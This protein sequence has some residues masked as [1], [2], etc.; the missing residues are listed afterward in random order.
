MTIEIVP[1]I[2]NVLDAQL[3]ID[4]HPISIEL[5]AEVGATIEYDFYEGS[6]EFIPTMQE[7]IANTQNLIMHDNV[8]IK[9]IPQNYG[10]ITYNGFEIT[11]S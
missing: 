3:T 7:Q 1:I 11:V 9:P 4:V 6:Y 8:V 10:L 5:N 2:N